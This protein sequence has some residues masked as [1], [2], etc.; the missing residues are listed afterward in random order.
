VLSSLTAYF[1]ALANPDAMAESMK[2]GIVEEV[3]SLHQQLLNESRANNPIAKMILDVIPETPPAEIQSLWEKIIIERTKGDKLAGDILGHSPDEIKEYAGSESAQPVILPQTN[4]LQTVSLDDYE[5]V[6]QMWEENFR[7]S[8]LP[9]G[10]TDR[11]AWIRKE[12]DK[13]EN[14]LSLLT[15]ND[16]QKMMEGMQSVSHLLPFLLLGG[17][18]QEECTAYLK[19]KLQAATSV[20][21]TLYDSSEQEVAVPVSAPQKNVQ[22]IAMQVPS[23]SEA[24]RQSDKQQS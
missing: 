17:F 24:S 12:K 5:A 22:E 19:A 18:S 4:K 2:K 15:S 13:M 8:E 11:V 10:E 20:S 14:V 16:P 23:S 6:R 21:S 7:T 1:A 9:E 3:L